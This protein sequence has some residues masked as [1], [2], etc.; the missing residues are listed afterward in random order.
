MPKKRSLRLCVSALLC[1]AAGGCATTSSD[2]TALIPPQIQ[3]SVMA[4][5]RLLGGNSGVTVEQMLARARQSG[6]NPA[7]AAGA[8]APAETT[9]S[10]AAPAAPQTQASAAPPPSAAKLPPSPPEPAEPKPIFEI[11]FDGTE[12]EP[13]PLVKEALAKKIKASRLS[14]KSEVTILTG[15]GPGTNAFEQ[16]VLANKRARTVRS[17]LPEGWKIEQVYDPTFPP[18]TVRLVLGRVS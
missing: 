9:G 5:E 4:E 11:T 6:D 15:P 12:E 10:I 7:P 14:A 8:Q 2:P 17:L 1:L 13:S 3:A 18:D 16:A